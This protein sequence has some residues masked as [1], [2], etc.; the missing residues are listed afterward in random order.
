[1]P[2]LGYECF[3]RS[4][5]YIVNFVQFIGFGLLP[6]AYFIIFANL[7]RSFFNEIDWVYEN[8]PNTIGSQWLSVLIL[9]ILVFPLIIKKKIQELKLAGMLLF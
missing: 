1:M 4:F 5:L 3:G 9:A 2:E 6:I 7:A 8:A